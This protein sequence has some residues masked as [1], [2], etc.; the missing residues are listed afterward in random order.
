[1]RLRS[2]KLSLFTREG[3]QIYA[4][5]TDPYLSLVKFLKNQFTLVSIRTWKN[6]I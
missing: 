2:L 4:L 3:I 6:S 5:T 1:M